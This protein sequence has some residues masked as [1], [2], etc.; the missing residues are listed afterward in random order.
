MRYSLDSL[1]QEVQE[2]RSFCYNFFWGHHLAKSGK[3]NSAC[4]SQWW[5]THPFTEDEVTYVTAEQYMMAGKARLFQDDEMLAEILATRDPK[6]V[7]ALGRKVKGFEQK[8][9]GQNRY[10]IVKQGNLLK[11][12]QHEVLKQYLLSTEDAVL[13]EASPYDK[14]W[15]IGLPADHP[16][17]KHPQHWNGLNLLGFALMEV[18]D[19]L[20]QSS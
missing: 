10:E 8:A 17:A 7:K 14:I 19:S 4:F 6:T 1:R 13:V 18:R 3:M 12:S 5:A 20:R 11:F 15:G 9:W 16:R 2:G